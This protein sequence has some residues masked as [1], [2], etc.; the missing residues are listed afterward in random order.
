VRNVTQ[1][2]QERVYYSYHDYD[3][4]DLFDGI[5]MEVLDSLLEEEHSCWMGHT[6]PTTPLFGVP[7]LLCSAFDV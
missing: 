5:S 3:Y 2:E 1:K 4:K 6:P 7:Q